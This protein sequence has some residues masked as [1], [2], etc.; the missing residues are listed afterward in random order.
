MA[1]AVWLLRICTATQS[2]A[3]L[4]EQRL[5]PDEGS[6]PVSVQ[7]LVIVLYAATSYQGFRPEVVSLS[8]MRKAAVLQ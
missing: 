3:I 7:E 4:V 8:W 6:L 5:Y 2:T 1:V